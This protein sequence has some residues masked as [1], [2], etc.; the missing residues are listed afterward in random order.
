MVGNANAT[1]IFNT[2]AM[3]QAEEKRVLGFVHEAQPK[4]IF[5]GV[6]K[7]ASALQAKVS[8]ED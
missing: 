4:R 5:Y 8:P 3:Y 7:A 1:A 6:E 2:G